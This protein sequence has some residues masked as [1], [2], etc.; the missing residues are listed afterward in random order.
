MTSKFPIISENGNEY[1]VTIDAEED[2]SQ[3]IVRV[4]V[5]KMFLNRFTYWK[6][7]S[8]GN[9]GGRYIMQ[10][11]NYDLIKIAKHAV[12]KYEGSIS[13][14]L[15]HRKKVNESFAKFDKWDGKVN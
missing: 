2:W 5:Q 12:R 3:Y 13:E 8:G 14:H 7:V 15:N 4:Y 6:F 1:R 9:M 11:W 10:D